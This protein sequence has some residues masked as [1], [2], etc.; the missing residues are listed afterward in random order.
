MPTIA[1]KNAKGEKL[2]GVTTVIGSNLGWSTRALMYW[3]WDLGMKQKDYRKTSEEAA[4]AG[5]IAHAMIE[6]DLKGKKFDDSLYADTELY[7]KAET[8]Y[9]NFLEW[10]ER[11]QVQPIAIEPHL[12]SEIHQ[13]GA[14]P[15]YIG[16]INGKASLLDWKTGGV[17]EDHLIQ[18]AAYKVAWEEVHPDMPLDGGF[19]LIRFSKEDAAF[20]HKFRQ[21]LP[22]AWEVF[23]CLLTIHNYHKVLKKAA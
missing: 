23:K 3:A 14:T 17:Y 2:S 20:D 16:Y 6:S 5:T 21:S 10:K 11:N 9:I 19:N 8:A 12:V 4:T 22:E 15:D 13:Y 18:L 1:Y 7:S